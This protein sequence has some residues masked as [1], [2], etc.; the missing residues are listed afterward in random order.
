VDAEFLAFRRSKA[1][2]LQHLGAF[3]VLLIPM[4]AAILTAMALLPFVCRKL[5]PAGAVRVTLIPIA[6]AVLFV[7]F[8]NLLRAAAALMALDEQVRVRRFLAFRAGWRLI[9]RLPALVATQAASIASFGVTR[10]SLWP[11]VCTVEKL[12]GKAAVRRSRELMAG[13]RSAGRALAI[14]H[15]VLPAFA[16]AGLLEAASVLWRTGRVEE[17]NAV[18]I[19]V[20]FPLFAVFA[21]APL[22]LYDRTAAREAGPLLQ[23]DR[24]PE[25]RITARP[26]SLSS[27]GWL[28]AAAI[29]LLYEPVKLW[30]FGAR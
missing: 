24:T 16:S 12:S 30:L 5:V 28:A 3:V 1:F 11:V 9:K 15:L 29:Y 19:A 20:W 13:L 17:P 18:A 10:D 23:L 27:I 6:S 14:R 25:L 4:Y 22:F 2:L 26:L 7:F 21:A 8:D